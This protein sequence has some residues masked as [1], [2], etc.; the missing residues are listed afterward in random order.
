MAYRSEIDGLRTL[1]VLP[2]IFFH[3]GFDVFSGGYVGVDVFFVISGYLI[4]TII[5][6]EIRSDTFAIIRFYERRARRIVPAL[7]VVCLA[8]IPF[9]WFWMLPQELEAFAK[10]LVAVNLFASNILFWRESGYFDGAAELKPLLHTWSLAVEEQFYLLFPLLLIA[11]RKLSRNWLLG[12]LVVLSCISLALAQWGS[13][14]FPSANFYLLPTRAW[15]LGIGAA[16]AVTGDFRQRVTHRYAELMSALGLLLIAYAVF[17]FDGALPFPGLWALVP[18]AGAA[19]IIAFTTPQTT[20]GRLLGSTPMV[21]VG[22]LSYSAYLWH[23]PLFAFARIRLYDGVSPSIYLALSLLTL[24]LA[25]LSWR[26]IERPFRSGQTFSRRQIF[27]GA[28]TGAIAMMVAGM[29]GTAASGLPQRMPADV[30]SMAAWAND[31]DKPARLCEFDEHRSFGVDKACHYGA[32]SKSVIIWGDSHARAASVGLRQSLNRNGIGLIQYTTTGC[33]PVLGYDWLHGNFD[34]LAQTRAMHAAARASVEADVV[35][36]VGRW[37]FFAEHTGFDNREGGREWDKFN[38]PVIEADPKAPANS[39]RYRDHLAELF[40][41]TVQGLLDAGKR[42]VLVYPIPEVGW[43]VPKHLAYTRLYGAADSH[44]PLSTGY[45]VFKV[46]SQRADQ[47]L[48]SLPNHRNLLRV[49]PERIF[50]NTRIANRCIAEWNDTPLY[51]D[52]DHL[53]SVGSQLLSAEIVSTMQR[54]GWLAE[55]IAQH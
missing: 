3:A 19:L 30:V 44:Q 16:L 29:I 55:K 21:A 33:A 10:S 11:L 47:L 17:T 43:D 32:F 41:G 26:F 38:Y 40:R 2:V 18:V 9:A 48:D 50:C 24:V 39:P 13:T 54:A 34:C 53:N 51:F 20:V 42:V 1:A 52:D 8:C 46:R 12:V 7:F 5:Y 27:A 23:Q 45:D 49:R 28:T 4:T 14:V 15:E 35:V 36:I 37:S 31:E 6:Q 25:Y 22:L